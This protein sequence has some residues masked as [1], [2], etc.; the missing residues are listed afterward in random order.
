MYAVLM[1][2]E[3]S[4]PLTQLHILHIPPTYTKFINLSPLCRPTFNLF[5][6]NLRFLASYFDHDTFMHLA[7]HV[8]VG[9]LDTKGVNP[10]E[11]MKH[12]PVSEQHVT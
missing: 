2:A 10:P 7:L 1:N 6:L 9:L 8:H 5:L 4:I 12:S 3:A 11:P